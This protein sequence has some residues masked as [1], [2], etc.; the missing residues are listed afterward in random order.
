MR[1]GFVTLEDGQAGLPVLQL[2]AGSSVAAMDGEQPDLARGCPVGY[3]R[4][5]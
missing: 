5:L 1:R 4:E 2:L 3:F